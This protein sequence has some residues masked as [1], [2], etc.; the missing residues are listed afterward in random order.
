MCPFAIKIYAKIVYPWWNWAVP[1]G[2]FLKWWSKLKR[3]A[4]IKF[5]NTRP[6]GHPAAA[7]RFDH[8][9]DIGIADALF[10]P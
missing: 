5:V 6:G 3:A 8:G 4:N 9:L 7:Q 10:N 2:I 1:M